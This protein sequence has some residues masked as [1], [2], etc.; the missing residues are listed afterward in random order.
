MLPASRDPLNDAE[1]R[2]REVCPR[3]EPVYPAGLFSPDSVSAVAPLYYTKSE[4]GY[5]GQYLFGATITLRPLPGANAQE[6]EWMLD[7]HA[8]RSQLHWRGEPVVPNDPYWVPGHVVRISVAFEE[9][10]TQVKIEGKD[11]ATAKEILVRA[12]AFIGEP[13]PDNE[14]TADSGIRL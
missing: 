6:L 4:R 14:G 5:Q 1:H 8:A 2:E 7:C 10:V 13:S 12:R 11:F 3:G 9:G